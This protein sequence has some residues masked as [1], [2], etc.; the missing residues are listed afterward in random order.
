MSLLSLAGFEAGDRGWK[1][2]PPIIFFARSQAASGR[3]PTGMSGIFG[4]TKKYWPNSAFHRYYP[5]HPFDKTTSNSSLSRYSSEDDRRTIFHTM[6]A[7]DEYCFSWMETMAELEERLDLV[8]TWSVEWIRHTRPWR[9]L[10][11]LINY[12]PYSKPWSCEMRLARTHLNINLPL[13]CP[14]LLPTYLTDFYFY[15]PSSLSWPSLTSVL[16]SCLSCYSLRSFRSR[17]FSIRNNIKCA[18]FLR[19]RTRMCPGPLNCSY[20]RIFNWYLRPFCNLV[21][22]LDVGFGVDFFE[23]SDR[24]NG[25]IRSE[26]SFDWVW[27]NDF[28]LLLD[29]FDGLLF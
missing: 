29:I 24:F 23:K 19:D 11:A 8:K 28:G 6:E 21:Q 18:S 12:C 3:A 7:I 10:S 9:S 5:F 26:M 14:P 25:F 15:D 27:C 22:V 13:H 16:T 20:I 17:I 2:F 1:E 4:P